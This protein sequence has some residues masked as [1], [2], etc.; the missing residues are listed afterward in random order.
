MGRVSTFFIDSFIKPYWVWSKSGLTLYTNMN[1]I[2]FFNTHY[3]AFYNLL[4]CMV[5]FIWYWT[6]L[7]DCKVGWGPFGPTSVSL[8]TVTSSLAVI[9]HN[10]T[11]S[12]HLTQLP[13]PDKRFTFSLNIPTTREPSLVISWIKLICQSSLCISSPRQFTFPLQFRPRLVVCNG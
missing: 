13:L 3:G 7:G 5:I 10:T 12:H 2:G 8:F 4:S 9:F 1:I 11:I 6:R